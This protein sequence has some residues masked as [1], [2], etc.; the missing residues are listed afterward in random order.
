MEA[1]PALAMASVFVRERADVCAIA[2][3]CATYLCVCVRERCL[4]VCV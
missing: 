4:C 3:R 2:T 1:S